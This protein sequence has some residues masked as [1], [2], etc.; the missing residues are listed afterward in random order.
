MNNTDKLKPIYFAEDRESVD[1]DLFDLHL[2]H[3]TTENLRSKASIALELAYRDQQIAELTKQRD[4]LRS[5]VLLVIENMK[6][7]FTTCE[8][9]SHE[10]D[11]K[12]MDYLWMLEQALSTQEANKDE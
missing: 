6:T 10:Q 1:T 7:G 11:V 3:L 4:E 2:D 8:R 9:C 12:D 5:E